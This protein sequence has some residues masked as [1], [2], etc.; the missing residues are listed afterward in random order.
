MPNAAELFIKLADK[1]EPLNLSKKIAF[2]ANCANWADI[3][4]E[5]FDIFEFF[6]ESA[7]KVEGRFMLN[8]FLLGKLEEI[9]GKP[10]PPDIAFTMIDIG[11]KE[12]VE[13]LTNFFE[14]N[15]LCDAETKIRLAGFLALK[16]NRKAKKFL[17]EPFDN[18]D[19]FKNTDTIDIFVSI[20]G[21]EALKIIK[22]KELIK[23]GNYY[24]IAVLFDRYPDIVKNFLLN[25]FKK[26]EI[27]EED[28][29]TV[30]QFAAIRNPEAY[31]Q[32]LLKKNNENFSYIY[33]LTSLNK[34]SDCCKADL[35]IGEPAIAIKDKGEKSFH[36]LSCPKIKA[37]YW[38]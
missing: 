8:A 27:S 36:I 14:N 11:S 33:S 18:P 30:I 20:K 6:K 19:I 26:G 29:K 13:Y 32:Y 31:L 22:L 23:S 16:G 15:N 38:S 2:T 9:L 10:Y 5:P 3:K 34:V 28:V 24:S 21:L 4:I 35:K 7:N 25:V 17:E 12:A 37:A 1:I